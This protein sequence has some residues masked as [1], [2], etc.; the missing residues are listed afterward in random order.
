MVKYHSHRLSIISINPL[1]PK[2]D[3]HQ[4]SPNNISR[5][6]RVKVMRISKLITKENASILNQILSTILKRNGWRSLWRICM[7]ILGLKGL[8]VTCLIE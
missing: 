4:F 7:W 1:G 3:Q 5:S 2:S 8:K 6:S